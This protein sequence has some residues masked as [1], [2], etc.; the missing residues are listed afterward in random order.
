MCASPQPPPQSNITPQTDR[1]YKIDYSR[2]GVVVIF[3]NKE[4]T[5]TE[6]YPDRDCSDKDVLSLCTL[7]GD[8]NYV[9]RP[10]YIN[11]TKADKREAITKYANDDYTSY[12]CLIIFIMS[13]GDKNRIVSSDSEIIDLNEFITPLKRN[14]SLQSKPKVFFIQACRGPSPIKVNDV[15]GHTRRGEQRNLG[16][17]KVCSFAYFPIGWHFVQIFRTS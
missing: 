9:V 11:Q 13:H 1:A 17:T 7:F 16:Y 6:A 14:A 10:L 8:L 3:N 5:D 15:Q 2:P 4:F 12:G